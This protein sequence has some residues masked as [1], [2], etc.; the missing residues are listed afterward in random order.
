MSAD[1]PTGV[2]DVAPADDREAGRRQIRGSSLLLVGRLLSMAIGF[3]AQVA[4]VRYL[5]KGDFGAFAYALSIATLASTLITFGLDR[6]LTRFVPIFDERGEREKAAGSIALVIGTVLALGISVVVLVFGLRGVI[7]GTLVDDSLAVSLLLILILLAPLQAIDEL[8]IG[9]FA[10]YERSR[11][12]FF[13]RY[14]LAPALRVVVVLVLVLSESDAE[15][16]AAGYVAAAALGLA[17]YGGVLVRLL[18][19]QGV[20]RHFKRG[21]MT[22]PAR[23]IFAFTVPLLTSDLVYAVMMTSDVLLLGYYAGTEEVAALRVVL[24]VA[25]LN[26]VVMASFA[27]LFTPLAARYFAR[28][29]RAGVNR[30]YWQ[31]ALWTAVLSFPVFALTFSLAEPVTVTLFGERYESSAPYLSLLAVGYYFNAL[32]GFNG[33]TLKVF[34]KLRYIVGINLLVAAVNLGLNLLL[35]PP[36]GALGAAIGTCATLILF[37]LL[38]QAGL[39]LGTGVSL[40]RRGFGGVYAAIGGATVCL[41]LVNIVLSPPLAAGI[42]VAAVAS[43]VVLL[44]GRRFLEVEDAFPEL[45]RFRAVRMLLRGGSAAS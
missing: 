38:K 30:L 37:N 43:L 17:I 4:T 39:R 41:L 9:L 10:V 34:G 2:S 12:I 14:V 19:E 28:G 1:G 35:I 16:L 27:L 31:T 5:S 36:F 3:G 29:D 42:A 21:A 40:F 8:V 25:L 32:L 18:R 26:D 24:P 23:S 45:M 22:M 20:T 15:F 7:E 6:A 33:L 13:R 11:T 44:V